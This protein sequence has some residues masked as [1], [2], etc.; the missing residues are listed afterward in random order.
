MLKS[1]LTY[2]LNIIVKQA[3]LE[4]FFTTCTKCKLEAMAIYLVKFVFSKKATRVDEIFT[5]DLTLITEYQVDGEDFFN[6]CCLFRKHKKDMMPSM[7]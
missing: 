2:V 6:F 1:P 3:C 4:A 5:V 7:Y